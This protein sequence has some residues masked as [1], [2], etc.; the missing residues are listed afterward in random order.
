MGAMRPRSCREFVNAAQD[1]H[2]N[3]LVHHLETSFSLDKDSYQ[4]RE[5]ET[6]DTDD[7]DDVKESEA[8]DGVVNDKTES[9]QAT[10]DGIEHL[11]H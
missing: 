8:D 11:S 2:K 4:L 6:D 9:K 3:A 7:S 5:S 10:F 1:D